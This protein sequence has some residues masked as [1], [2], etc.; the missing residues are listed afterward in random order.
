MVLNAFNLLATETDFVNSG[1]FLSSTFGMEG[2]DNDES[3]G[4]V[5]LHRSLSRF[6]I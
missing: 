6:Q 3:D 4:A 1:G 2:D 5:E